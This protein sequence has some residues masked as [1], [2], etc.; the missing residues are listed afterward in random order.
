MEFVAGE[1]LKEVVDR[2]P[3][4]MPRDDVDFWF[5]S[6]CSGVAVLT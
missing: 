6:I 4:G 3:S 1:S 5:A 2:N